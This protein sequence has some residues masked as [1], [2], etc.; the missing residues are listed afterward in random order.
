MVMGAMDMVLSNDFGNTAFC[1]LKLAA[2]K[3]GMLMLEAV[4]IT[5][6]AA[7]K[8]LQIERYLPL[9]IVRVVVND[10]LTDLSKVLTAQHLDKLGQK[11]SK[12]S[13]Q[14]FVNQ[15]RPQLNTMIER[16][17]ELAQ[18]STVDLVKQ[19]K[20]KMLE[21]HTAAL[22]RLKALAQVNPNIRQDEIQHLLGEREVLE[23]YLST[24]QLKLDAVRVALVIK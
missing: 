12:R 10:D 8:S 18:N 16:A 14:E 3:E 23:D 20:D 11:V 21:E 22:Q 6:C 2:L 13:A 4:F 24:A 7:P 5:H 9:S 19:A 1:T 15:A 17:N